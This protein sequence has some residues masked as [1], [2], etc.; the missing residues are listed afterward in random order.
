MLSIWDRIVGWSCGIILRNEGCWRV[1]G[2]KR[3]EDRRE[4]QALKK[5]LRVTNWEQ[6]L[7]KSVM[8]YCA[9]QHKMSRTKRKTK[10]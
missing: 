2:R 6:V 3:R 5:D 4:S 7:C 10:D 8:I 1:E 9:T